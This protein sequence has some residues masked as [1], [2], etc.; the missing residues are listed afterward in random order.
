MSFAACVEF[1]ADRIQ[2][3]YA[4]AATTEIYS[5]TIHLSLSF[6]RIWAIQLKPFATQ[7]R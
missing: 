1:W 3:V 2:E 4:K 5:F 7:R 6:E